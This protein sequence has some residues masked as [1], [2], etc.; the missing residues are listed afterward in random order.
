MDIIRRSFSM[1]I[2]IKGSK[3]KRE[4]TF[5]EYLG[6]QAQ[7]ALENEEDIKEILKNEVIYYGGRKIVLDDLREHIRKSVRDF[8]NKE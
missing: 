2:K 8:L 4:I 1:L 3:K 5:Q 7:L 6:N